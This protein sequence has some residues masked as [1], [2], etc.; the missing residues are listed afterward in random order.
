MPMIHNRGKK[1]GDKT[2]ARKIDFP[3]SWDKEGQP[4]R[5]GRA[6]VTMTLKPGAHMNVTDAQLKHLKSNFGDEIINIDDMQDMQDQFKET[7]PAKPPAGY[8][9]PDDFEAEV[10][11][12]VAAELEKQGRDKVDADAPVGDET[13]E[14]L[15]IRLDAMDRG[16]L[17]ALIEKEELPVEHKNLKNLP[18]LKAAVYKALEAKKAAAAT[19]KAEAEKAA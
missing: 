14:A 6:V 10:A 18:P 2:V 17:V 9:S 16:D 4:V 8:V 3:K 7:A 15:A 11:K 12:R 13:S 1:M 5:E 19:A